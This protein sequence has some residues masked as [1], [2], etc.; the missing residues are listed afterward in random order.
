[1]LYTCY[2]LYVYVI[3]IHISYVVLNNARFTFSD[4]CVACT[5]ASNADF[6]AR[7][8]QHNSIDPRSDTYQSSLCLDERKPWTARVVGLML[9]ARTHHCSQVRLGFHRAFCQISGSTGLQRCQILG[10]PS[11]IRRSVA[12]HAAGQTRRSTLTALLGSTVLAMGFGTSAMA[13][14]ASSATVETVRTATTVF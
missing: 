6:A 9:S 14:S 4:D 13:A 5:T 7:S 11:H 8:G 12:G 1:M 2:M 10:N 3:Y